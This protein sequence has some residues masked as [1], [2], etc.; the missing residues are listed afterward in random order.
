MVFPSSTPIILPISIALKFWI[1]LY[2]YGL[3][4]FTTIVVHFLTSTSLRS[5][6]LHITLYLTAKY[7]RFINQRHQHNWN[8]SK[9][10]GYKSNCIYSFD[11]V[12][13]ETLAYSFKTILHCHYRNHNFFTLSQLFK[14]FHRIIFRCSNIFVR[15]LLFLWCRNKFNNIL[16]LFYCH[17]TFVTYNRNNIW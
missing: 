13:S 4:F 7:L 2:L 12:C 5:N 15:W 3:L 9:L 10:L 11:I 6:Y 16:H 17:H 8:W 14:C 1:F